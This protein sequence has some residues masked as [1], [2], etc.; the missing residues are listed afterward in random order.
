[1]NIEI[2]TENAVST[3]VDETNIASRAKSGTLPVFA[4]P[5]M[6]AL[7]EQAAAELV[8]RSLGDGSTTVGIQMNVSHLAATAIGA[9]VTATA[10]V[11]AVDRR[12]IYFEVTAFDNAG[13]IGKGEH[14]RFVVDTEKFMAKAEERKKLVS[15][16]NA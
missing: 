5:C 9:T 4:T 6:I 11:T 2:G 13:I 1:M 14:T 16:A 12:K 3:V 8:Q 15:E 10:K 7:M